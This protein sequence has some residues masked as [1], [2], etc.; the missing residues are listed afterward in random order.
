MDSEQRA[1][2][3]DLQSR[4]PAAMPDEQITDF[5]KAKVYRDRMKALDRL[6]QQAGSRYEYSRLSSYEVG[7]DRFAESRSRVRDRLREWLDAFDHGEENGNLLFLG[8]VGTG[9]DHLAYSACRALLLKVGS[10][11]E[12]VN[13]RDLVGSFRDR[14]DDASRRTESQLI[15]EFARPQVLTISDPLPVVGE[16]SNYQADI[17]YRIIDARSRNVRSTIVTVN[18]VDDAEGDKRLG[19]ATWDR[20]QENAISFHC[21][22]PSYRKK[23]EVIQ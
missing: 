11:V 19:V 8:P 16:L 13:G 23:R 12:W 3:K 20:L 5:E 17:L 6:T 9:K 7:D 2:A 14:I 1:Q 21:K 15:A 22:W 4:I 18:V 10:T